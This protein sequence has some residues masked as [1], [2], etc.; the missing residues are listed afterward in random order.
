MAMCVGWLVTERIRRSATSSSVL[1]TGQV[2]SNMPRR[3]R[4]AVAG[5]EWQE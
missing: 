4:A 1:V 2:I 5:Y 3:V